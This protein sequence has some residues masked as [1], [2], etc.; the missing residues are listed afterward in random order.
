MT[1]P[2]KSTGDKPKLFRT[3]DGKN[4]A[5]IFVLICSLFLLWGFAHALLDVLN[6]HFQNSL[7]VTKA[8]SGCVRRRCLAVIF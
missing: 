2:T 3:R 4:Y 1:T 6:K 5:F 8:Q 7:E